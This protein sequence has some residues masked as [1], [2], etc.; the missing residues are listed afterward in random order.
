ML[1][2][3]LLE[4]VIFPLPAGIADGFLV[5]GETDVHF[6]FQ[7]WDTVWLEPVSSVLLWFLFLLFCFVC[8]IG[9]CAFMYALVLLCLESF[10]ESSTTSGSYSLCTS[11]SAW[12]LVASCEGFDEDIS[13]N[14]CV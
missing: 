6:P 5:R 1:G 4:N 12:L 8:L 3:S 2:A 10:L 7:C 9:S 14:D 11:S 13:F